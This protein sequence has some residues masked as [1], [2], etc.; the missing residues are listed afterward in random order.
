L[1]GRPKVIVQVESGAGGLTVANR[2]ANTSP[3]DDSVLALTQ[4][5]P[6]Q[7]AIAG[8]P[9]ARFDPAQMTWIGSE[10][11]SP[12]WWSIRPFI[13][14][15]HKANV[16]LSPIDGAAIAALVAKSAATPKDVIRRYS[17]FLAAPR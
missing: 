16:E 6:W 14:D 17:S 11:P 5:V 7:V 15:V 13:D 9:N 4:P 12:R 1:P 8:D 2:L 10:R 3:R